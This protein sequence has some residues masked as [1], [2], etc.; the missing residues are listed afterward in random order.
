MSQAFHSL[1]RGRFLEL[2]RAPGGWEYVQRVGNPRSVG[3]VALT[4]DRC[5]I[6]ISQY[7]IPIGKICVEIPAGLVGD[8]AVKETWQTGA[9]RELREETGYTASDMEYL[10]EGPSSAGLTTECILL[11]R[12]LGVSKAGA[13]EPDGDEQITVHE[14]PLPEVPAFLQTCVKKGWIIDPKVYAA[15]YFLSLP[16]TGH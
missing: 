3:I 16:S 15:L 11:A 14:V 7:R 13:P 2:V 6:L 5:L 10:T 1:H 8:G 9:I 12:A 4:P